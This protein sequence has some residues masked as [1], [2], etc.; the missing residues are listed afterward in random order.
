MTSPDES[1]SEVRTDETIGTG[2]QG[3]LF[4]YSFS[5]IK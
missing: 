4:V 2:D 5:S 1:F 3:G